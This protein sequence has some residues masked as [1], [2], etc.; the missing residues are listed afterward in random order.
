M[1]T[2]SPLR[3]SLF[4]FSFSSPSSAWPKP[5][6]AWW[7]S[8]SN[9]RK[10]HAR[11]TGCSVLGRRRIAR[12]G[13]A[14]EQ[15]VQGAILEVKEEMGRRRR[16]RMEAKGQKLRGARLASRFFSRFDVDLL[17]GVLQRGE[18]LASRGRP[19]LRSQPKRST[20]P[21]LSRAVE[22]PLARAPPFGLQLSTFSANHMVRWMHCL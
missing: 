9:A 17:E 4:P 11:Q 19:L 10:K 2:L 22:R 21:R 18:T 6:M 16:W 5:M 20:S 7:T 15:R 3:N 1:A 12:A 14:G 8:V 13:E